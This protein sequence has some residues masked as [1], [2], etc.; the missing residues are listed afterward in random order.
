MT[1]SS[2]NWRH[3]E[4]SRFS[5]GAKD[6]PSEYSC[7]PC[8]SEGSARLQVARIEIRFNRGFSR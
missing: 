5:G 3:P 6:L 8:T 4:R 1:R 7:V 2:T